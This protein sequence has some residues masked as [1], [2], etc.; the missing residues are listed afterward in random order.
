MKKSNRV[1]ARIFQDVG[2]YY[3]CNDNLD[4]LDARGTS[5]PTKK[6]AQEIAFESGYTHGRGSGMSSKGMRKLTAGKTR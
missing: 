4:Y 3:I 6:M 1:V 5:Y 2:G